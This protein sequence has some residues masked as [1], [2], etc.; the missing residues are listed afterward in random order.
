M[1]IHYGPAS[2]AQIATLD[3]RLQRVLYK[4]ANLAPEELDLSVLVGHRGEAEQNAAYNARPQRS[5]KRWPNSMHNKQPS[6]AFDFL[7]YPA[8][9]WDDVRQ[10]ARIA[11]ALQLVAA[12]LGI[13]LRWGG[14]W[15][16]DGKTA[17]EKFL[18]AGHLELASE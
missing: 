14:D 4:F 5:K 16:Q 17:D 1:A 18:D 7:P 6:L 3:G 11:G 15:D 8:R 9:D 2:R 13:R 12:T 10:F